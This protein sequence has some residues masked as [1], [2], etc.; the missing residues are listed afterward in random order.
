MCIKFTSSILTLEIWENGNE[1][2]RGN[3]ET[4][5]SN[6]TQKSNSNYKVLEEHDDNLFSN[7]YKVV[8]IAILIL[9]LENIFA[10]TYFYF[11][12]DKIILRDDSIFIT[13]NKRMIIIFTCQRH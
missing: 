5:F 6:N 1:Y 12:S 4:E 9:F 11:Y 8:K 3:S 7:R 2:N 10:I 13:M